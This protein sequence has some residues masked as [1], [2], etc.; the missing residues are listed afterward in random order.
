MYKVLLA[1]DELLVRTSL[2]L[3]LN[4]EQH[5]F[6]IC[7]EASSGTEALQLVERHR[8]HLLISDIRMPGMDGVQLSGE[9][10]RRYPGTRMIMLSNYDDFDYVKGAL[11]NGA[12]EYLLKHRLNEEEL[13]VALAGV[14]EWLQA[15]SEDAES[16]SPNANHL[17]AL[18]RG[19]IVQLIAGFTYSEAELDMHIGMLNLKLGKKRFVPVILSIDDYSTRERTKTMKALE[20]EQFSVVNMVEEILHEIGNGAVCHVRDDRFVLLFSLPHLRSEGQMR[21]IVNGAAGRI[22]NCLKTY[23]NMSVSLSI[24][25]LCRGIEDIPASYKKAE[26]QLRKRFYKG[27]S[28]ILTGESSS[29]EEVVICGLDIQLEKRLLSAIRA[30]NISAVKEDLAHIFTAIK[31]RSLSMNSSQLIFNDLLGLLHR[32]CKEKEVQLSLLYSSE[33]L[34]HD[35]LGGFQTLD[36]L[37]NWFESLFQRYFHETREEDDK[38]YSP[39]T[40]QALRFI[41]QHYM[42]DIS[43]SHT[44][45]HIGI[46]SAYLSTLFKNE[47]K[48]GFSD[49]LTAFR[50]EQA[51]SF[52]E[53]GKE[54][55]D[56]AKLCGFNS[57]HYFFR[58][59][60]KRTGI[61]PGEY[62]KGL[63]R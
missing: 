42:N 60:K 31:Q 36:E 3:L 44:A 17:L 53:E 12:S 46:S 57:Q 58:I 52:L 41:R 18:K 8:P 37:K 63:R 61:T 29:V 28:L 62:V 14:R 54:I 39:Y 24:G 55:Q 47:M 15:H 32:V 25:E 50:L 9:M 22:A 30:G 40:N 11:Q 20:L 59:F 43:L 33:E 27:K 7:G 4:W 51:K 13:T 19:F 6:S 49:Y 2:K 16:M 56:I 34:P 1:D 45:E 38:L 5:G 21:D 10:A 48:V 35:I 23:L 26:E